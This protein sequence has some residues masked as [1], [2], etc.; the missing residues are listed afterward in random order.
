MHYHVT[1]VTTYQQ[2][3]SFIHCEKTNKAALIDPGGDVDVLIALVEKSGAQLDKVLLT[4]GHLDHV[5]GAKLMADKFGVPMIGPHEDDR[6]WF[7]ALPQQA[8]M[9]GFEHV[10]PFLPKQWLNEGDVV[11]VG[12]ISLEVLHCPGHTPGHIAF[13]SAVDKLAFVGDLL[14]KG[15]VGR[16]DFPQGDHETLIASIKNKLLP[17]GDEVAFVPGHGPMSLMGEERLHN[18]FLQP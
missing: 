13:Y 4:H 2:N 16:S 3:C 9:F 8:Q 12:E 11:S 15:S 1:P 18:P 17:L 10:D 5:G 14:F 6:F 7:D